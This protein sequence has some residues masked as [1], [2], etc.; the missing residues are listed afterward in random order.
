MDSYLPVIEPQAAIV[1][2]TS[3]GGLIISVTV[4]YGS[5][6]LSFYIWLP[7]H[8]KYFVIKKTSNK[9]RIKGVPVPTVPVITSI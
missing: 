6:V 5:V 2:N 7:V 1:N 4:P 8:G 9:L 3:T